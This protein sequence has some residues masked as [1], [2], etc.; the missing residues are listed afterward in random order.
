M[1]SVFVVLVAVA[2]LLPYDVAA[3]SQG[4]TVPVSLRLIFI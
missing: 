2:S 4:T 3:N 1:E